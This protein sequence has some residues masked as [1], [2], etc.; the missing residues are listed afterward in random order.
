[1]LLGVRRCHLGSQSLSRLKYLADKQEDYA[2]Q[3]R[4][5][6]EIMR[7]VEE[8]KQSAEA[9]SAKLQAL[10]AMAERTLQEASTS[11]KWRPL[12]PIS[13][14]TPIE[15][16][17][18]PDALCQRILG[19][20]QEVRAIAWVPERREARHL[21]SRHLR[22]RRE[23]SCLLIALTILIASTNALN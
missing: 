8:E 16:T 1:M 23:T 6:A 11:L 22:L 7:T 17:I 4:S 5:I 21:R 9:K 19:A 15:D 18:D 12:P 2:R 14:A 20:R 13:D 3:I 10:A